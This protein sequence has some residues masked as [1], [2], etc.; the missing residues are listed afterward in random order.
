MYPTLKRGD[1][2]ILG[3]K[4]P[5]DIKAGVNDGDILVIRGPQYFYD[6]GIDPFLLNYLPISTPIIHR[7]IEKKKIDDLWYF[8]TKGDNSWIPD[9]SLKIVEK[10]NTYITA[11]YDEKKIIY[12]PES[13][14]LGVVSKI[15]PNN[16]SESSPVLN[17]NFIINLDNIKKL[18]IKAFIKNEGKLEQIRKNNLFEFN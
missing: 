3:N 7:A 4:K 16:L 1:V 9:G 12:V 11:I 8:K 6:N 14:I 18:E 17:S 15:I 13:E 2:V 5:Q 10:N